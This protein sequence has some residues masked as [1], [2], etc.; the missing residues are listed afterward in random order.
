M[1]AKKIAKISSLSTIF[2]AVFLVLGL[3]MYS[4]I[5]RVYGPE[6]LG[7]FTSFFML[8]NFY[9][10]FTIFGTTT[11]ISKFIAEYDENKETDNSNRIFSAALA[12]TT[13]TSI[14]IGSISFYITPPIAKILHIDYNPETSVFIS[15]AL[16]FFTY[17][18]LCQ[19][20]YLGAFRII[21]SSLI[22]AVFFVVIISTLIL[23][24]ST[25]I[26]YSLFFGCIS[27]GLMGL[28]FVL[29][30]RNVVIGI[31][32]KT[33]QKLLKFSLPVVAGAILFFF[34]Q[35]ID[36]LMAGLFLS[37]KD[38]GL[39]TGGIVIIQGISQIPISLINILVPS[40]SKIN[41]LG[42]KRIE[43]AFN[44]NVN[45]LSIFLFWTVVILLLFSRDIV[46]ILYGVN[47]V[48][49]EEVVVVVKVLSINLLFLS[50][51]ISC[52]TLLTG[53]GHPRKATSISFFGVLFQVFFILLL[54]KKYGIIGAAWGRVLA[55]VPLLLLNVFVVI[56]LYKIK[57]YW[58]KTAWLLLICLAAIFF[59][60]VLDYFCL[61]KYNLLYGIFF[62]LFYIIFVWKLILDDYEKRLLLGLFLKEGKPWLR[63]EIG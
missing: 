23:S 36:R 18:Q 40:Y 8:I 22:K 31:A 46:H 60:Y 61:Y 14:L 27:T 32:K 26:Y 5:G 21:R 35:W 52:S 41:L 30:D 63:I 57:V 16:M 50:F 39:L 15:V 48:G 37:V 20:F 24:R 11:A 62:T 12:F 55:M 45:F 17:S 47:N 58:K 56:R 53:G 38:I 25:P 28:Y 3:L 4:L 51:I 9:A 33:L 7:V 6:G 43:K 54:I 34:S 13:V 10:I 29:K 44:I 59:I 1:L 42:T 19:F 49:F 2:T